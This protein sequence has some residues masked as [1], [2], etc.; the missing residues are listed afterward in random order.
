M[1]RPADYSRRHFLHWPHDSRCETVRLEEYEQP[2]QLSGPVDLEINQHPSVLGV[3]VRP[4]EPAGY[5]AAKSL[6]REHNV[7]SAILETINKLPYFRGHI[8]LRFHFGRFLAT[9]YMLPENGE[10]VLEDYES[11]MEESQ[12]QGMITEE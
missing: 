7:Y 9:Q 8:N 5:A 1:Y 4:E 12:F 3:G 2:R 10:Y 6:A 11:M